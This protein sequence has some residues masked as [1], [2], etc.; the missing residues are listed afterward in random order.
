MRFIHMRHWRCKLLEA[1]VTEKMKSNIVNNTPKIQLGGMPGCS[2]SEHLVVLKTWIKEKEEKKQ[3]GIFQTFDMAK[4]FDKESLIDCMF[5]LNKKA[6]ID[7][8]SVENCVC[9]LR[10]LSY[11]AQE[12]DDPVIIWV[13]SAAEP[14]LQPMSHSKFL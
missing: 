14:Q 7:N 8:K 1:L 11:C 9:V 13:L 12:V 4:F 2:S 10:N 5:T 3:L 6:N